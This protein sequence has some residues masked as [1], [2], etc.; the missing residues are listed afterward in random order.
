MS[1]T[2][3]C[4]AGASGLVGS[5][6]VK[7]ALAQGYRVNGTLRNANDERKRP[8]LMA[9]PGAEDRLTLFSADTADSHSFDAAME[10]A[11]AV[12]IA[13]FPPIYKAADGT[14]A[15]ALDRQRGYE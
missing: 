7:R 9:L 3:L 6:I 2:I 12:F 8:Y 4:I 13:C 14:P 11:D 1:E 5:Q 15:K 10:Y